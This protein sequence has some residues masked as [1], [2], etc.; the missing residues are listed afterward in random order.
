[1]AYNIIVKADKFI[2]VRG[3]LEQSTKYKPFLFMLPFESLGEY[4]WFLRGVSTELH[5]ILGSRAMIY[6]AAAVTD[7]Y[8]PQREMVYMLPT[9]FKQCD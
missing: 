7:F 6:S 9:D 3:V 1:L 5:T 8:I 2:K 4:L